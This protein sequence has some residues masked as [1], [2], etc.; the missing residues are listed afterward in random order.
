MMTNQHIN[1]PDH[2]AHV[3]NMVADTNQ[4]SETPL[5]EKKDCM[6]QYATSYK[7]INT[8]IYEDTDLITLSEAKALWS[9]YKSQFISQLQDDTS[10]PE[11]VIW[12][13]CESNTDYAAE[14]YYADNNTKT[15]GKNL[16]NETV[17]RKELL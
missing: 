5:P 9:K 7:Y 10:N 13:D 3:R 1:Q 17:I 12:T 16:W 11:M 4:A 8:D 14:L 2:I 6:F 15:D